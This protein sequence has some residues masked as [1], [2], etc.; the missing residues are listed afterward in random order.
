MNDP[1]IAIAPE[2]RTLAALTHLSGLSGY[3]V[4]LGGIIVP[5]L[6]WMTTKDSPVI[7]SIA[8]QAIL[9]N[10]SVFLLICSGFLLFL[11]VILIPVV[12]LAWVALGLAAVAL[13]IVGAIRANEGRYYRYPVVGT[14]PDVVNAP[15]TI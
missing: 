4:P 10:V 11:T 5:I 8:K 12:I 6:I 14:T 3:I 2:D 1:N 13:P 15:T 9:L 7:A